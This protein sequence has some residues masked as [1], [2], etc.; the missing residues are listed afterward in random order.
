MAA[1]RDDLVRELTGA[2]FDRV[3]VRVSLDPPWTTDWITPAGRAAL[4]A[5]GIS[6]P[7]PA[8]THTGPIPLTLLPTARQVRCPQCDSPATELV[9]EFGST[10]CKAQY[11][12]TSCLEP[13]DHL[14]EI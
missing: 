12:C 1:M 8:P 5:A 7:G 14:K 9:S 13:F 3:E 4:A 2:G 10:A 6:P 11:R